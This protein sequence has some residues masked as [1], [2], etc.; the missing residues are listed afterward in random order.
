MVHTI[1]SYVDIQINSAR[2][3]QPGI[4]FCKGEAEQLKKCLLGL[5][6]CNCKRNGAVAKPEQLYAV[7]L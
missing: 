1:V 4:A 5:L 7:S 2:L 6:G 3:V